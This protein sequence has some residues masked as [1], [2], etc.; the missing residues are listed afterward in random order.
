MGEVPLLAFH[1]SDTLVWLP[2]KLPANV[3]VLSSVATGPQR[4]PKVLT[5]F[6]EHNVV[7]VPMEPLSYDPRMFAKK[8]HRQKH[9]APKDSEPE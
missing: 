9:S 4:A 6:G 1:V 8:S 3:R 5:A 7:V 2:E